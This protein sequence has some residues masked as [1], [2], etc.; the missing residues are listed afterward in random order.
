MH[1]C[2]DSMRKQNSNT[3]IW[4]YGRHRSNKTTHTLESSFVLQNK[5]VDEKELSNK[6]IFRLDNINFTVQQYQL[7]EL[8]VCHDTQEE[9]VTSAM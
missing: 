8:E 6:V 4:S 5:V 2:M 3:L 9:P 7:Q 1:D